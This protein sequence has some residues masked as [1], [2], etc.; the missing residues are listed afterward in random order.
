[1]KTR[2]GLV[3]ALALAA[4]TTILAPPVSGATPTSNPRLVGAAPEWYTPEL[5][6][7]V[8]QAGP[9][10]VAVPDG[11]R[12]PA[13]AVAYQGIR[14]GQMIMPEL[15]DRSVSV[16]LCST[17]FVFTRGGR[18]FIGTAGHCGEVGA[19]VT[20]L[21]MPLGLV[22]IGKVVL[23]VDEPGAEFPFGVD[24]ALVSI[25]PALNRYVSPSMAFW[26]GPTGVYEGPATEAVHHVGWGV[27]TPGLPRVGLANGRTP[28]NH[29]FAGLASPGD[30][31]SGAN[32]FGGLAVGNISDVYF[33]A[34]SGQRIVTGTSIQRILELLGGTYALATCPTAEPWAL[35]GC[36]S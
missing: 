34:E 6:R 30:S 31:G 24:F 29:F 23:S 22:H 14:P 26:G 4:L 13:S 21:F 17:N 11:V 35:P 32:A 9:R 18:Y 15:P 28:N 27:A 5:H 7:A 16:A 20:M 2:M 19:N 36:P 33:S 10:G 1:M 12:L 25:D 8:L 3:A